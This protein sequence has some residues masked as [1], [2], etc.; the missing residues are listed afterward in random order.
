MSLSVI[1]PTSF[2]VGVSPSMNSSNSSID[3]YGF[4]LSLDGDDEGDKNVGGAFNFSLDDAKDEDALDAPRLGL[5]EKLLCDNEGATPTVTR[6]AGMRNSASMPDMAEMNAM[7]NFNDAV[8]AMNG[9]EGDTDGKENFQNQAQEQRCQDN[10]AAIPIALMCQGDS[11][12]SSNSMKRSHSFAGFT[13]LS[14]L[15]RHRPS[16]SGTT[17]SLV[18]IDESGPIKWKKHDPSAKPKRS[19]MKRSMSVASTASGASSVSEDE[20]GSPSASPLPSASA[21][22]VVKRNVSFSS[23]EIFEHEVTL[24]DNPSVTAGPPI[25]LEWRPHGYESHDVEE[26]EKARVAYR[27]D[28]RQMQMSDNVRF[29]RLMRERGFTAHQIQKAVDEAQRVKKRR[30][31]TVTR[32]KVSKFDEAMESAERKMKRLFKVGKKKKKAY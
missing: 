5:V 15:A 16:F 21:A 13:G 23:L 10:N 8:C 6:H 32:L 22:D 17:S 12:S 28:K 25:T 20:C 11:N 27:R 9:S 3:D 1:P 31:D 2:P 18:A 30:M 26:Y 4:G 14:H 7:K 19:S 24:G 29:W